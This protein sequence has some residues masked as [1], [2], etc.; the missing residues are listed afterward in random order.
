M[1]SVVLACIM[2]AY[3]RP[4]TRQDSLHPTPL[5]LV[6]EALWSRR[7]V[8]VKSERTVKMKFLTIVAIFLA[9]ALVLLS[10]EA[11][12]TLKPITR[13]RTTC[14]GFAVSQSLCRYYCTL[15]LRGRGRGRGL[16]LGRRRRRRRRPSFGN[17]EVSP[18]ALVSPEA[19]PEETL[20]GSPDF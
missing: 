15:A 18:E 19:S 3:K 2:F 8:I 16:G 12:P 10:S 13:P 4:K 14:C 1:C 11:A 17:P 20:E 5:T 7:A 9:L 6:Q